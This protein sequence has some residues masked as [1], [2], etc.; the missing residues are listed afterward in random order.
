MGNRTHDLLEYSIVP[1]PTTPP[2]V[3]NLHVTFQKTVFIIVAVMTRSHILVVV[4][5][6]SIT[7]FFAEV[8]NENKDLTSLRDVLLNQCIINQGAAVEC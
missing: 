4:F 3:P 2:R 5:F 8:G 6:E 1:Q 7:K